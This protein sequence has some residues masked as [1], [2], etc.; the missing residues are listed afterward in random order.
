METEWETVVFTLLSLVWKNTY[1]IVTGIFGKI[2]V[3]SNSM[4]TS[5]KMAAAIYTYF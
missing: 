1:N 5:A 4:M 2:E 3:H